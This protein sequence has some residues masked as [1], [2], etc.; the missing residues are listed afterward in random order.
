MHGIAGRQHADTLAAPLDDLL[1]QQGERAGPGAAAIERSGLCSQRVHD[2]ERVWGAK[3][4][5]INR[6]GQ[7]SGK[8]LCQLLPPVVSRVGQRR[9]G[10]SEEG[11]SG[12]GVGREEK[13]S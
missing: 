4:S 3:V 7:K 13:K 8:T 12:D 2:M 5:K 6:S 11:R 1:E 9:R 10:H